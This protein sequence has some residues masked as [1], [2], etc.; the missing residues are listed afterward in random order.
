MRVGIVGGGVAGLTLAAKLLQQGRT[1]VVIEQVE[2]FEDKGYSLGI[3][4]LGSSVLHGL[5]KY[6]ELLERGEP[7]ETYE[8]V[9]GG[10]ELLQSVDLSVVRR[11]HRPDGAD[12]PHRPDRHPRLGGRGRRHPDGDDDR[13]P[14]PERRRA[15]R[16]SSA[17]AAPRSSTC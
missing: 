11:R 6:D 16:S 13:Q 17:T 3:Y 10:G 14:R 9:N 2:E 7:A 1:P 15:S 4:P 12:Q 5:G 8:V